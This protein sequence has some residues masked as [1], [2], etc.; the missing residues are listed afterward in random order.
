M[1][2]C[3]DMFWYCFWESVRGGERCENFRTSSYRLSSPVD[4]GVGHAVF[5]L[6]SYNGSGSDWWPSLKTLHVKVS[7]GSRLCC[8]SSIHYPQ[9]GSAFCDNKTSWTDPELWNKLKDTEPG[10]VSLAFSNSFFAKFHRCSPWVMNPSKST[11]L[12]GKPII[13]VWIA[14]PQ[15]WRRA[16]FL[17]AAAIAIACL[18]LGLWQ[19]GLQH[20]LRQPRRLPGHPCRPRWIWVLHPRLFLYF[21]IGFF[22]LYKTLFSSTD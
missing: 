9:D 16:T 18:L 7:C 6:F 3:F 4:A 21:S 14:K 11:R 15:A 17:K 22:S 20:C 2:P 19:G 10:G 8:L 5:V 1:E 13:R 12:Q